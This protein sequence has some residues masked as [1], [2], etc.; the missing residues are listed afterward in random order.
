MTGRIFLV[1]F[2]QLAGCSSEDI[3]IVSEQVSKNNIEFNQDST[4]QEKIAEIGSLY[5]GLG[6]SSGDEPGSYPEFVLLNK[7]AKDSQRFAAFIWLKGNS[8]I[9][10]LAKG[11]SENEEPTIY[12]ITEAGKKKLLECI[13]E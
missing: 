3:L 7:A 13:D 9:V 4:D 12:E 1:V 5:E 8:L 10:Q 2:C 6:E 11:A